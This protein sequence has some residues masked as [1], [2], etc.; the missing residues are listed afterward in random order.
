LAWFGWLQR[1]GRRDRERQVEIGEGAELGRGAYGVKRKDCEYVNDDYYYV[2][3]YD[4]DGDD[5]DDDD[6]NFAVS[7]SDY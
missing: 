2:D 4:D 6:D 7:S 3:D 1:A 5:D